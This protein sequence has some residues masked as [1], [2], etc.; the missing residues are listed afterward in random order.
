VFAA[1]ADERADQPSA[2]CA[3]D[4]DKVGTLEQRSHTV[5]S[6]DLLSPILW[7]ALFPDFLQRFIPWPIGALDRGRV[8]DHVF[9]RAW[10]R[11]GAPTR[12]NPFRGN[13]FGLCGTS[14]EKCMTS[15]IPMLALNMTNVESGMQMV[16]S[17]MDLGGTGPNA[18]SRK[19]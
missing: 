6:K 13:F 19:I 18:G 14:A 12:K 10:W 17:P 2:P 8:L 15:P 1:M 5:L 4:K 11:T 3:Q 9:E 16:L 7:A